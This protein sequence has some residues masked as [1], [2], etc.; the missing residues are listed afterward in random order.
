MKN[1]KTS[2]PVA[3]QF[4]LS[5]GKKVSEVKPPGPCG[6]PAKATVGKAPPKQQRPPDGVKCPQWSDIEILV[7]SP[8]VLPYP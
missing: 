1:G 3:N 2:S 8:T 5:M 6:T 4:V 7:L